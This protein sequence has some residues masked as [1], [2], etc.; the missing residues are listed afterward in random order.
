VGLVG[1]AFTI[2][3][4][5]LTDRT[6]RTWL[7]GGSI[8]IWALATVVSG[9]ATSYLWLV[10]ARVALGVVTAT[11]GPAVASLTGDYFPAADRAPLVGPRR[12]GPHGPAV[13]ARGG[14]TVALRLHVAV[15]LRRA[16]LV[17]GQRL[18]GRG[19]WGRRGVR[20]SGRRTGV[21]IPDLPHPPAHRRLLAL[22][23]LRTYPRDVAT[24]TESAKVIGRGEGKDGRRG[25]GPSFRG[26]C[27]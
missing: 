5:L 10:L 12:R 18:G 19:L 25:V 23:A 17:R 20:P 9:A 15:R 22:F 8:A 27:R 3:A 13:S 1:A 7:L 2:P 4:G 24:A 26:S 6:R 21:H 16:G 14:G 11:T